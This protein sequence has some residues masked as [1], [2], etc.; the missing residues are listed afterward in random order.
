[1]LAETLLHGFLSRSTLAGLRQHSA[2]LRN[3]LGSLVAVH[4]DHTPRAAPDKARCAAPSW[5]NAKELAGWR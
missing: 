5:W 3:Q 2:L 4:A 1:M